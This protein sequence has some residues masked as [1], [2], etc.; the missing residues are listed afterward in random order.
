MYG[1]EFKLNLYTKNAERQF[2]YNK[3]AAMLH[4]F[5]A[6]LMTLSVAQTTQCVMR[7]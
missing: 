5:V 4:L 6:Y 3:T 1:E 2:A 7:G